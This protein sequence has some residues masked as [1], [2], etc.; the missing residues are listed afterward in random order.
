MRIGG[1]VKNTHTCLVQPY[2]YG[3][4]K[5]V[6]LVHI[7]FV[8]LR[9]GLILSVRTVFQIVYTVGNVYFVVSS[10]AG[11]AIGFCVVRAFE[12]PTPGNYA[13]GFSQRETFRLALFSY[14]SVICVPGFKCYE[15][16]V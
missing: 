10:P 5:L 16:C 2:M 8:L 14:K 13:T 3:F 11:F 7:L 9:I 4:E 12:S 6:V 15:S 1:F